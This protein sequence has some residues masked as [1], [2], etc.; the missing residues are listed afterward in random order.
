MN[1]EMKALN[2]NKTQKITDLL[3]NRKVIGSK[4]VYEVKFNLDGTIERFKERLVAKSFN[5]I[6]EFDYYEIFTLVAKKLI[7]KILITIAAMKKIGTYIN[8][9]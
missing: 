7:V 9:M 5:Q 6:E 3:N 4:W 2:D 1:K 8:L